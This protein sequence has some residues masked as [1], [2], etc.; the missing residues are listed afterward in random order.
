MS[1]AV[2]GKVT[3]SKKRAFSMPLAA[4]AVMRVERLAKSLGVTT[5]SVISDPFFYGMIKGQDAQLAWVIQQRKSRLKR[6]K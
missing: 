1:K 2:V 3:V 6:R 4:D 5:S